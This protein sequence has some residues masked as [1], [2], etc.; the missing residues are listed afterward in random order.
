MKTKKRW[1]VMCCLAA[2]MFVAVQVWMQTALAD[3]PQGCVEFKVSC[4]SNTEAYKFSATVADNL[5]D[6]NADPTKNPGGSVNT[7][8]THY[9]GCMSCTCNGNGCNYLCPGTYT[10]GTVADQ[11]TA[12]FAKSCVKGA[13]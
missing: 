11:T 10:G 3:C 7:T 1:A 12:A 6:T 2:A 5:H 4:V 13:D 9:T 8:R